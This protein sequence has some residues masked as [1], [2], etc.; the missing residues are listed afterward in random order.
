M[1]QTVGVRLINLGN[2]N[3]SMPHSA[4]AWPSMTWRPHVTQRLHGD[5]R[6]HVS[7]KKEFKGQPTEEEDPLPAEPPLSLAIPENLQQAAC[8]LGALQLQGL[9]MDSL[10]HLLLRVLVQ[11]TRCSLARQGLCQS[12]ANTVLSALLPAFTTRSRPS[13]LTSSKSIH[14][15]FISFLFPLLTPFWGCQ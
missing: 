3:V 12:L 6:G 10:T 2:Q 7:E 14:L 13:Y 9:H 8:G 15:D 5:C 11:C 1:E 4:A